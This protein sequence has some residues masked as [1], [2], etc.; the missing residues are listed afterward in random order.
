MGIR[1]CGDPQRHTGQD[2]DAEYDSESVEPVWPRCGGEREGGKHGGHEAGASLACVSHLCCP[3]P[4]GGRTS[5]VW[6]SCPGRTRLMIFHKLCVQ[7]NPHNDSQWPHDQ[8]VLVPWTPLPWLQST[9][10]QFKLVKAEKG[11]Y[12]PW[13][14]SSSEA[15][16][17]LG[18][19]VSRA[20]LSPGINLY[21][22]TGFSLQWLSGSTP[23]SVHERAHTYTHTHTRK[24]TASSSRHKPIKER[25]PPSQ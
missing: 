7:G 13:Y 1:R 11:T 5:L 22:S 25:T 18:M 9:G 24:V 19:P 14:L 2:Q 17:T 20:K 4:H 16:L 3:D 23:T 8:S 6:H 12:W 10:A 15:D 21:F